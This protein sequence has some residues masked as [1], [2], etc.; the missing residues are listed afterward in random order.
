MFHPSLLLRSSLPDLILQIQIQI[1]LSDL[2]L[3]HHP[4]SHR[5]RSHKMPEPQLSRQDL[6]LLTAWIR[7]IPVQPERCQQRFQVSD[8]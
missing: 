6:F 4:L 3:Q 7:S 5:L 2:R 1:L 8:S